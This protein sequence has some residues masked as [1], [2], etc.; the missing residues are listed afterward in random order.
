MCIFELMR[1]LAL[2][3]VCLLCLLLV[4]SCVTQ[5]RFN[6]VQ[7]QVDS[8]VNELYMEQRLNDQLQA[9]IETIY[10][11]KV[12]PNWSSSIDLPV[13]TESAQTIESSTLNTLPSFSSSLET[14]QQTRPDARTAQ[15]TASVS[16]PVKPV[17]AFLLK[18]EIL[19]EVNS[20]TLDDEDVRTLVPIAQA[21]RGRDDYMITIEGHT[22]NIEATV[23]GGTSRHWEL[24]TERAAAIAKVMIS[25]GISPHLLRVSG[26]GMFQPHASNH[27]AAGQEKNRRAEIILSP[28][29]H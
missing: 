25:N 10:Y 6:D 1:K 29:K 3:I 20:A 22:D 17:S 9:Y 21:L 16:V 23:D 28:R 18:E 13:S 8:L 5:D 15:R 14:S 26:R 4:S 27:T 19:F 24:S 12:E 11:E 2:P 7:L